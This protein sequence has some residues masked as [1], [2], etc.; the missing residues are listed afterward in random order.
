M[1]S[2]RLAPTPLSS[3]RDYRQSRM[4]F[5]API[6]AFSAIESL[7]S[8][9]SST[10]PSPDHALFTFDSGR[11]FTFAEGVRSTL[12]LGGTGSGKTTSVILP[13]LDALL[14]RGFG[15]VILDVKGNLGAQTRELAKSCGRL[16]DVVE[17]GS[18]PDAC[19]T[20][21]L[22]GMKQHEIADFFQVLAVHGMERDSNISWHAKG[23]SLAADVAQVLSSLAQVERNCHFSRQFTPTLKAV[24]AALSN[25]TFAANLWKFYCQELGALRARSQHAQK[26]DCLMEAEAFY[27]A[28]NAECFH[29]LL[30]EDIGASNKDAVTNKQQKTWM[31]QGILGRFKA[32][33]ATHD[34]IDRFSSLADDAVPLD[35]TDLVYRQKKVVLVHFSPDCGPTGA[36]LSR[37]IKERFYQSILKNGSKLPS[38]QSVIQ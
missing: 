23:G 2:H 24:F 34:L 38:D 22:A 4:G 35:F 29:V 5:L 13:M 31:L 7:S 26:P 15:G 32:I 21:L 10:S 14:R 25:H 27:H 33:Q 11:C 17:F 30:T 6:D 1:I 9:C 19:A 18:S 12:V 37:C 20:N 36:L 28:V 16:N 3:N 8:P